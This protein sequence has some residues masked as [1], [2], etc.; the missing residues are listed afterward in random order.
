[1]TPPIPPE[2]N[3]PVTPVIDRGPYDYH[4]TEEEAHARVSTAR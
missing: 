4:L 2:H 3:F 1:M